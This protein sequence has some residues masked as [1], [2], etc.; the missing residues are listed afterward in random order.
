VRPAAGSGALVDAAAV[1]ANYQRM[2][3]IADGTGIPVDAALRWMSGDFREAL[4]LDGFA[5]RRGDRVGLFERWLA[6]PARALAKALL[7]IAGRRSRRT[8][9]AGAK[10]SVS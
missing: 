3:R 1:I 2:V 9:A 8:A 6:P 10:T 7:R 4:G 5:T